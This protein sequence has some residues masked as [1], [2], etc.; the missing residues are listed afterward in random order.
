MSGIAKN[1]KRYCSKNKKVETGVRYRF[2]QIVCAVLIS[3]I[4]TVSVPAAPLAI[5]ISLD[6]LNQDVRFGLSSYSFGASLS[7][8]ATSLLLFLPAKKQTQSIGKIEILPG[9]D[10]TRRQGEPINFS[11]IGYTTNGKTASGLKFKWTI[12]DAGRNL[13]EHNL[14]NGNFQAQTTGKFLVTAETEGMSAQVNVVVEENKALMM[15]KIKRDEAK[16]D[17]TLVN[18]LKEKRVSK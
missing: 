16:G 5:K 9:G 13:K 6:E 8:W 10:I 12:K 17:F 4:L 11:A 3:S 15:K 18:K 1:L 7:G 14:A 2:T